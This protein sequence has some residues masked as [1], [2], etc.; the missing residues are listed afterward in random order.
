M[1]RLPQEWLIYA[2]FLAALLILAVIGGT[3]AKAIWSA[4]AAHPAN[5]DSTFDADY[6]QGLAKQGIV[7]L[8][9]YE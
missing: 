5:W 8:R 7:K 6:V 9:G 2:A 3:A 4:A 1:I